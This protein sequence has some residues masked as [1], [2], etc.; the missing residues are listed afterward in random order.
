MNLLYVFNNRVFFSGNLG[1]LNVVPGNSLDDPEYVS[2]LNYYNKGLNLAKI[3][4]FAPGN[5]FISKHNSV[6]PCT[7]YWLK[8]WKIYPNSNSGISTGFIAIG[9][10]FKDYI[11]FFSDRG[12]QGIIGDITSEQVIAH[13]SLFIDNQL[14]KETGYDNMIVEEWQGYLLVFIGKKVY[15]SDSRYKQLM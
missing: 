14:L 6:L 8:M 10:N 11:W 2:D 13:R 4:E 15:L 5:T 9:V 3:K 7:Y 12:L 1:Y